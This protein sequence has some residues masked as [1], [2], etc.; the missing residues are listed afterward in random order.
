MPI[1][2]VDFAVRVASD[3]SSDVRKGAIN[4]LKTVKNKGGK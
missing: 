2:I 4:L 1:S 3:Q